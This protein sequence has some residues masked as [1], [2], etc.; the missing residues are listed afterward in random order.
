M[1]QR[2]GEPDQD[3][4]HRPSGDRIVELT[5]EALRGIAEPPGAAAMPR[6]SS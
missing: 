6:A 3:P 2:D 5:Y 4:R 1:T